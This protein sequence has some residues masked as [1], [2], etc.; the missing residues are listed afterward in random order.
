MD[1]Y[2]VLHQMRAYYIKTGKVMQGQVF[3]REIALKF[4]EEDAVAGLLLFNDY[5]DQERKAI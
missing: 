5:L 2:E 4:K 3:M 1:A